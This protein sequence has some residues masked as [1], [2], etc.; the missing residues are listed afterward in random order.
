MWRGCDRRSPLAGKTTLLDTLAGRTPRSLEVAG[1][2][3]VNG[4]PSQMSYGTVAYVPQE[5]LLTGSLTV[6]ETV[7]FTAN[8]R[9]AATSRTACLLTLPREWGC[10]G[11]AATIPHCQLSGSHACICKYELLDLKH[12]IRC[13]TS[14][15][16]PSA[17]AVWVHAVRWQSQSLA[18]RPLGCPP[19]HLRSHERV[20]P[21]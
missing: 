6:R 8:L 5:D 15:R 12:Q 1:D 17:A 21:G 7:T 13:I 16:R 14:G 20:R 19:L 9:C 3:H 10:M 4:R 18:T 11:H 2:I